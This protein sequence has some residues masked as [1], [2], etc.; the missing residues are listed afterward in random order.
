M[1]VSG[2]ARECAEAQSKD[3]GIIATENGYNLYVG[4]NG[5][6]RPQ[7]AVL[8]TTDLDADTLLTYVDRILMFYIRT[9]DRLERTATWL[10]KLDG[11]L[12]YLKE[13][14]IEDSLGLAADLDAQMATHVATYE[15][16]WKAAS[17]AP[18]GST[19]LSPSPTPRPQTQPWSLSVNA[20]N[21]CLRRPLPVEG[22]DRLSAYVD[23]SF[24]SA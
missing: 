1:A 20:T 14:V 13:V 16:E 3:I 17:Q 21:G 10:N 4:G 6:L 11:W 5:G 18:N 19:A 15:C 24:L 8:F 9:A 2:C 23:N 7:H 12:D 22:G